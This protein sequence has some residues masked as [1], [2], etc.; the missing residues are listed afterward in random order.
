MD[1]NFVAIL[2]SGKNSITSALVPSFVFVVLI[3]FILGPVINFAGDINGLIEQS[4]VLVILSI[5]VGTFLQYTNSLLFKFLEGY[6]FLSR[7]RFLRTRK[8][9]QAHRLLVEREELRRQILQLEDKQFDREAEL[10]LSVLMD[11][12]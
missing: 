2:M 6:G 3:S 8:L 12:H 5:I 11:K 1:T 4:L 10:Q 9:R 7:F